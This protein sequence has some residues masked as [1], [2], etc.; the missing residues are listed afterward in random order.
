MMWG[1]E[2]KKEREGMREEINFIERIMKLG[3]I[4]PIGN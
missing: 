1:K 3:S 2:R 4:S